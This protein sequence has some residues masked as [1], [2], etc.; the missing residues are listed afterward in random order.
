MHVC[1]HRR[2]SRPHDE[3]CLG[4]GGRLRLRL[5]GLRAH[6]AL[7]VRDVPRQLGAL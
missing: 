2:Y 6:Q 5:H 4:E 3:D 7:V 1:W